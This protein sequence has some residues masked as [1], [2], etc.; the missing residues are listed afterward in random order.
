MRHS[1]G[2]WIPDLVVVVFCCFFFF[3]GGGIVLLVFMCTSQV[4]LHAAFVLVCKRFQL[5]EIKSALCNLSRKLYMEIKVTC[6]YTYLLFDRFCLV[7]FFVI[8]MYN[9]WWLIWCNYRVLRRIGRFLQS[10]DTRRQVVHPERRVRQELG[11]YRDGGRQCLC[12][13]TGFL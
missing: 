11:V 7:V 10:W 12:M 3:E 9:T 8:K 5:T 1:S 2:L 13:S 6:L 4:G